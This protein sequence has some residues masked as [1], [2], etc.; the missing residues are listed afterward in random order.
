MSFVRFVWTVILV[1]ALAAV[2][3]AQSGSVRGRVVDPQR[4]AVADATVMLTAPGSGGPRTART[5][6][7]GTFTFEGVAPGAYVLRVESTGFSPWTQSVDVTGGERTVDALLHIEGL[8]ESVLVAAPKLEE[9]LPQLIERAGSRVQTISSVDIENGGYDDVGQTLQALVPGLYVAPKSGAFDYVVASLQGSR[10]AEILWLVD[11]V[12]ISNRLY[13]GTTPLDTLPAHMV[14]RIEII[15]GGQGLFYGTQAVA[16]VINVVTKAF[17]DGTNGAIRTGFHTNRG[18]LINGFARGSRNGHRYVLYGSKDE[19]RGFNSFPD[20]EYSPTTS[21]RHRSYDVNTFGGKYAYDFGTMV[22]LSTMYQ[23]SGVKVDTLRPARSSLAQVGG[24]ASVFNER[25]EHI[26]SAKADYTPH[27][28]AELF[29]KTYYHHWDSYYNESRNSIASP[30]TLVTISDDEFW[31]FKD[32]G[33]NVMA[34]LAPTRGVEYFAGYDFQNYSGRDDVLLIAQRTERV[35]A[36]FGQVR[37]LPDLIARTTLALGVRYNDASNADNATVWNLT[38]RHDVTP[39][40]FVRG[41]V[42]TAFRYP[43]AYQLFAIDESCCIGNPNLEPERSTN[44]NGSVGGYLRAGESTISL[45]AI[46]FYR[47]ITDLIIEVDHPDGS[48]NTI[49]TNGPGHVK[50][51]GVTIVGTATVNR[52]LS[53]SLGYTYTKSEGSAIA[54]G[55]YENLPGIPANLVDASFDVH[56]AGR[57]F[58]FSST[59]NFVGETVNAA[60]G[61]GNVTSESYTL[62]DVSGRYFVDNA[63]RHRINVRL[64]NLFDKDYTTVPARGFPDTGGD[65]FVVHNLGTPRTFH[66]SYSFAF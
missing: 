66:L 23:V 63:R 16:G 19:A 14:E 9:E 65:A 58:G 34:K 36:L 25:T 29:F 7:D 44:V 50:A 24:Q 48:G 41:G 47:D 37:A 11:G 1:F 18:G 3:F 55:G 31:G 17:T 40:L 38:G 56:P 52:S 27:P 60:P 53:G 22:R 5:A 30:G 35:N 21:D 45:E 15:E 43:D 61:F 4:V 6:A 49:T 10:T 12:R 2:A 32:Y 54:A 57:P 33:L 51:K 28:Q 42:G 64:E 39:A 13:N 59:I 8:Q 26:F 20:S 46:G 62:V